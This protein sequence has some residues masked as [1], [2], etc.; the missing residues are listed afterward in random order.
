MK[1]RLRAWIGERPFGR[2]VLRA[3]GGYSRHATSQLAAA[4]SFRLLFSLVP[5]AAFVVSV[6][7]LL[8]P[9]DGRDAVARWLASVVPGRALD[10]S[11]E[12]ARR[13]P[14]SLRRSPD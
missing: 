6:A 5:L 7:D 12:H 4:V 2:A 11:I 13:A 10:P 1:G 14:A 9:D 3:A 8:L